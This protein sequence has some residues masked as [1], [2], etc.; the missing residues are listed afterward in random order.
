[1]M[2]AG[3]PHTKAATT[4]DSTMP[5]GERLTPNAYWSLRPTL[6]PQRVC[7]SRRFDP[8]SR[9][10]HR[11]IHPSARF[12]QSHDKLVGCGAAERQH[13]DGSLY[14]SF[15]LGGSF[16]IRRTRRDCRLRP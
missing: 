12:P 16:D 10:D 2:A 3:R 8:L 15:N 1:M 5:T 11:P 13:L 9:L 14:E 4:W 7:H 6:A